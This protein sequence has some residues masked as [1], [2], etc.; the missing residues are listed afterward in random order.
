VI[1]RDFDIEGVATDKAKANAPLPVDP[2]RMV[3][4]AIA[5]QRFEFI[6]RRQAHIIQSRRG[7]QLPQTHGR[8]A[9][10]VSRQTAAFSGGEKTLGFGIGKRPD[11]ALNINNMFMAV[12]VAYQWSCRRLREGCWELQESHGACSAQAAG[13]TP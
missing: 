4:L 1:V 8:T 3:A 5:L 10:Y 12:K 7:I 13:E 6:R 11:H 2:N 9:Q